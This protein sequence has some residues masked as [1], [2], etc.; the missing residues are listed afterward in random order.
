M[1]VFRFGDHSL[2]AFIRFVERVNFFTYQVEILRR[3][4]RILHF[5][6]GR[7]RLRRLF[8]TLAGSESIVQH[9]DRV[10]GIID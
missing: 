5:I 1:G 10:F 4:A 7:N 8:D 3:D 6:D 2:D 9:F